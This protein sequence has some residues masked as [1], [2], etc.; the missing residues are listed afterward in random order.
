MFQ[1]VDQATIANNID[2]MV[3]ILEAQ[4]VNV[5]L[6]GSPDVDSW[7]DITGGTF[8]TG[9]ASF[10][11]DIAANHG[12][13]SLVDSM[14]TI[15]KDP[16]LLRDILHTNAAGE[17]IY[18]ESV[19]AAYQKLTASQKAAVDDKLAQTGASTVVDAAAVIDEVAGTN[20]VDTATTATTAAVDLSKAV[21]LNNGT[22]LTTT[23]A[24]VD[25]EGTTVKDTG[26]AATA[27]L[28]QQILS[29]N[30]TDKWTGEGKGT[31]QA[32]AA[33]M[34]GILSG[35][36][37]TDIKQ[38]GEV[39]VY[40]GVEEIGKTYNGQ[41]VRTQYNEDGTSI[42][43]IYKGS[44]QYDQDGNEI[45]TVV[46]VPKD[47]K[48]ETLYGIPA[49]GG[50]YGSYLEPVDSSKLIAKDGKLVV[51]TGQKTFGNK[52]TGQAVPNT[53][54]E[55]QTGNAF[56]GTF[57]GS[58]NTGYRVQFTPD[59]TPIF[60]T[61]YA[62]SNDLAI[63][64]QDLGPIG[65][66]GLALATGGLSIPQQIAAQLAVN[67]L[68]GKDIGDAIKSAAISF[69]G[70]QIPGMDFMGD[71]ASFIKDLGLPAGVTDSLTKGFQNA[72][73][74]AGTALLSGQD[75]GEAMTRGFVTG[76]TNGAVN[77]L[78][79]NIEGFG[80][81]TDTQKKLVTN[82]VTGVVSGKP[83]DQI[84][85]NSAISLA[86]AAVADAKGVSTDTNTKA[87]TDTSTKA[88]TDTSTEDAL[89]K[90]GLVQKEDSITKAIDDALTIDVSGAKDVNTAAKS[91]Q[92]QGYDKF[93]FD[94]KTYTIDNN[95]AARNIADLEATVK[96]ETTTANLKGEDFEGYDAAIAA[97][98]KDN[99]TKVVKIGNTEANDL[100]EAK[101]LTKLRDPNAT[102]FE[103]DGKIYTMGTSSAAVSKAADE[104]R[105][106]E[107]KNNIANASSRAEAYKIAR[108]GGLGAKDVFTWNGKS[109]SAAT[110][111][112][113][114]DL[115]GKSIDALNAA[116]LATVTDASSTV[117][118]QG[119]TAA[120]SAA[121]DASYAEKNSGN[122]FD[123]GRSA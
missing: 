18:N 95:N 115:S 66:I 45:S 42:N 43:Y 19:I 11:N 51:D 118:A 98:A 106:E 59:G 49:D 76:G 26:S 104:A 22:F 30:L 107:L 123:A 70:A 25:S 52:V 37:I 17:E 103:Y 5:V 8:D 94:G 72:A 3:S 24:I 116:N 56:G 109:Y 21:D 79:G 75:I 99:A 6:T 61:T 50:E 120:R 23:G 100:D 111:E 13:V 77:S 15:L 102:Q 47:A 71:G 14:G 91:A 44:G 83:L 32:N 108:E 110:A 74:S 82:A 1:G 53:Y 40:S 121:A 7:D 113:R 48:L 12:N 16:T 114:P 34:A 28:T 41:T 29:Q 101:A 64:M 54:S 55:R 4:G 10:Y 27:T 89:T 119:D 105:A 67:V 58:G 20:L 86:T 88:G 87:G 68:S 57:D 112:E 65:Q 9:V 92:E 85:I 31:A 73:V 90:A 117:A 60:Y 33:D 96:A 35:I 81:L 78:L 80:D 84:V 39:P 62:T 2:Q 38:F 36:G 122:V 46:E 97:N 63:L 93:T 69:A